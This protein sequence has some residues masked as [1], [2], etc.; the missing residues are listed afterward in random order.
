MEF[1]SELTRSDR[2]LISRLAKKLEDWNTEFKKQHYTILDLIEEEEEETIAQEQA[3]LDE[4]DEKVTSFSFRLEEL[5]QED[6]AV[7]S[8]KFTITRPHQLEKRLR[9]IE[10]DVR[11]ICG[12]IDDMHPGPHFDG[13]LMQILGKRVDQL[14]TELSDVTR[15]ILSLDGDERAL[16]ETQS[17]IKK[18]LFDGNLKISRLRCE[19]EKFEE[20]KSAPKPSKLLSS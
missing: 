3:V 12:S 11:T 9:Y 20:V 5:K 15:E 2:L 6:E 13:C 17:N 18:A 1:K 19:Q 16:M 10:N 8:G 4:Y 7:P 14:T